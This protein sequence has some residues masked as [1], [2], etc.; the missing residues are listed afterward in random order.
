MRTPGLCAQEKSSRNREDRPRQKAGGGSTPLQSADIRQSMRAPQ[1]ISAFRGRPDLAQEPF[2]MRVYFWKRCLISENSFAESAE[3]DSGINGPTIVCRGDCCGAAPMDRGDR[4]QRF[5][6]RGSQ[7]PA[8]DRLSRHPARPAPRLLGFVR[9]FIGLA[10]DASS[11]LPAAERIGSS[12]HC[13][14][15]I[16]V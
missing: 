11:P 3:C 8:D 7:A 6:A 1:A 13:R 12:E 10:L 14:S 16:S 4:P 5:L 9:G 15:V 2:L